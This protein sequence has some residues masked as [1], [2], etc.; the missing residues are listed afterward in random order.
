MMK[1]KMAAAV[2]AVVLA[3]V[4]LSGCGA[5]GYPSKN[6]TVICPYSAGGTTDL[7]IRGMLDAIPEKTMPSGTNMVVSN[8]AGGS[9]IVGTSQLL[10]KES[11]G[12]TIGV[13][14]CDLILNNVL[15][16]TDI[17]YEDFTLLGCIMDGINILI[18]KADAPYQTFEEFVAYAKENPGVAI[19][20]SGAGTIP[21]LATK[22]LNK[23]LGTGFKSVSYDSAAP[24]VIAVVSGEIPAAICATP[25]AMGQLQAGEIKAI[26]VTSTERS[27]YMPE[28]PAWNESFSELDGIEVPVWVFMAAKKDIPEEAKTFLSE[29]FAKAISSEK[30]AE[31][32][33]NFYMEASDFKNEEEMTNFVKE[34]YELYKSLADE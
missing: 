19:G 5:K 14:N 17:T 22:A 10:S 12:Y 9:G 8:V 32:R 33:K 20:D 34:Q 21:N 11:D 26:A 6:V 23:H 1:S 2:T 31:T 24:S 27:G 13:V 28:V 3:V 25:A 16:N 29:A 4:S 18:V 7:T 30:F 15:G